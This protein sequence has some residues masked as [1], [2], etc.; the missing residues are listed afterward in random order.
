MRT[1]LYGPS[2][3]KH[4]SAQV[5]HIPL[6]GNSQLSR[7]SLSL[8]LLSHTFISLKCKYFTFKLIYYEAY[9]NTSE[10][11]REM[12]SRSISVWYSWCISSE[13]CMIAVVAKV[14]KYRTIISPYSLYIQDSTSILSQ[15]KLKWIIYCY[16]EQEKILSWV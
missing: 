6:E 7:D 15:T 1:V 4:S 11:L 3:P 9:L 16:S 12:D 8:W 5:P 2:G 10:T 14:S 13:K